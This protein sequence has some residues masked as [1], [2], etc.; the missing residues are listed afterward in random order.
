MS[1]LISDEHIKKMA[2]QSYEIESL[3][4]DKERLEKEVDY[5]SSLNS[6]QNVEMTHLRKRI[7]MYNTRLDAFFILLGC[8]IIYCCFAL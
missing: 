6:R 2:N 3:Q 4:A 7:K 5:L 8:V 1:G